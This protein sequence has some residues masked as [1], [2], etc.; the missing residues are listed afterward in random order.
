M[1]RGLNTLDYA[2]KTNKALML[3]KHHNDLSMYKSNP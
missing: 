2:I 1:A 3:T